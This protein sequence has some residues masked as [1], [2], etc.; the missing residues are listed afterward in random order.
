[1]TSRVEKRKLIGLLPSFYHAD[2]RNILQLRWAHIEEYLSLHHSRVML[3][4]ALRPQFPPD[5]AD[6]ALALHLSYLLCDPESLAYESR[7]ESDEKLFVLRPFVFAAHKVS[8]QRKRERVSPS[9][10]DYNRT[11]TATSLMLSS[12]THTSHRGTCHGCLSLAWCRTRMPLRAK[13]QRT[14]IRATK[15]TRRVPIHSWLICDRG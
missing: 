6:R 5:S 2:G 9:L 4:S 11:L 1:M 15:R 8:L 14:T 12:L 7:D 3:E 10:A 13:R